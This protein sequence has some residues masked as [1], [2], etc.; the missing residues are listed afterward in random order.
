MVKK[1]ICLFLSG[2]CLLPFFSFSASASVDAGPVSR[3]I[4]DNGDY[5]ET[6]ITD[7][8]AGTHNEDTMSMI[9]R[10]LRLLRELVQML[11]GTKTVEKVKYVNYYDKNGVLLWSVSLQ[12]RFSYS[13]SKVKCESASLSYEI[14]DSDWSLISAKASKNG[15]RATGAFSV[16]QTKLGVPLKLIERTVTL[17][18]DTDGNVY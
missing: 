8:A 10:L 15:A 3:E 13:K 18:C 7:S 14:L 17:T 6:G 9:T 12:A 2:L 1:L 5:I 11:T 16:R 4:M